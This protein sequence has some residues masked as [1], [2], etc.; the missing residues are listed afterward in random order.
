M[1]DIEICLPRK[2]ILVRFRGQL[3]AADFAALDAIGR[4]KKDEGP[5]DC[6]FD[7]T[8]VGE[9]A[10]S[11]EFVASRGDLPQAYKDRAR[12]YVV[13]NPDLKLLVRLYAEYQASRG[14]RPPAVVDR[15]D[16]ALAALDLCASDFRKVPPEAL[17]QPGW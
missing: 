5:Y 9:T 15:L 11:T 6:I 7:M 8:H 4:A 12:I 1:F 10:L 14:W 13:P 17:G 2:T 16:E 3:N